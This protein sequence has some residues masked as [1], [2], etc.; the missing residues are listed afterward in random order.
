MRLAVM[1]DTKMTPCDM[2]VSKYEGNIQQFVEAAEKY[3]KIV[4]TSD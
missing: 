1:T 2:I 4:N 3:A